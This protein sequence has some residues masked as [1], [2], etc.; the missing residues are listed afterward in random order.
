M[1]RTREFEVPVSA[2]T[3]VAEHIE[4]NGL[5]VKIVGPHADI[6]DAIVI[7]VE[8]E[9]AERSAVHALEDLIEDSWAELDDNEDGDEDEDE[10]DDDD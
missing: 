2:M 9:P 1:Q 3:E 5:A 8:F 7:E 6:A 10:D 4:E